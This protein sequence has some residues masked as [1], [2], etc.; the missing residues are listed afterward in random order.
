MVTVK[1]DLSKLRLKDF[2]KQV[3]PAIKAGLWSGGQVILNEMKVLTPVRT[4]TLKRSE[5]QKTV[6]EKRGEF[7]TQIGTNVEYAEK[8]EYGG[9]AKAPEGFARKALDTKGNK[10]VKEIGDAIKSIL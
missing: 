7:Y 9:S 1:V 2:E 10:A 4:G 5:H 8:I 6:E 3:K